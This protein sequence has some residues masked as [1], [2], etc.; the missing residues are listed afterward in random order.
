MAAAI[1]PA[2]GTRS[3]AGG[4]LD[5][6]AAV[7]VDRWLCPRRTNSYV[8]TVG[9]NRVWL[10]FRSLP[11]WVQATAWLAFWPLIGFILL[12]QWRRWEGVTN[13]LALAVLLL[14]LPWMAALVGQRGSGDS[15]PTKLALPRS[16]S[17][18]TTPRRP[19]PT[20]P[21]EGVPLTVPQ[22][23][24]VERV[25]DGDT[26]QVRVD[27]PGGPLEAGASYVVRLLEVDAPETVD[28]D[29][30]VECWGPEAAAFA[31]LSL[32]VSSPVYMMGDRQDTDRFG[33]HLRYVW[34]VGGVLFNEDAVRR[35][36]ARVSPSATAGSEPAGPYLSRLKAAESEARKARRGM[37]GACNGP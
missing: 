9:F 30:P 16:D 2:Y 10:H 33:R 25:V 31:E 17:T 21:P 24:T 4:L 11:L 1:G 19:D 35:G 37:W 3:R 34:T 26:L 29:S 14:G 7:R 5:P 8:G 6:T 18:T 13:L 23:G 20:T 27:R 36:F 15:Q 28:P 12:W 32:P 22:V